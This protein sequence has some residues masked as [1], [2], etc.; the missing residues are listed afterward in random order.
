[1]SPPKKRAAV[2][3]T[4]TP[5]LRHHIMHLRSSNRHADRKHMMGLLCYYVL[6]GVALL[7]SRLWD[8]SRS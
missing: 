3:R 5:V 1:M 4:R 7:P 2:H 6:F 8:P